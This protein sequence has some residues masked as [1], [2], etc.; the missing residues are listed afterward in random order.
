M[1]LLVLFALFAGAIGTVPATAAATDLQPDRVP[2]F[3]LRAR[4][5]SAGGKE[6]GERPFTF[7]VGKSSARVVGGAW[8]DGLKFD[9]EAVEANLKGYPALYMKGFPVVT[10]LTVD[11][12]VDPTVVEAELKFDEGGSVVTLKGELFGPTLGLVIWRDAWGNPMAATKAGYNR[13][14]WKE[15]KGAEVPEAKRVEILHAP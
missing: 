7:R 1:R 12:V 4:V 6:P 8:G 14:Y 15:L 2:T 3:Q 10:A 13:R 9:R 11:G 5:T